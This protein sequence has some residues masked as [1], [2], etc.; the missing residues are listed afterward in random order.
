MNLTAILVDDEANSRTILRSYLGKYCPS[1]TVLGEAA[2]VQ[3]TLELLKTND[4]DM[5][6]LDVE[7][8]YGNAFDLIE[9]VPDRTFEI[10][11][12]T[13][14]DH[15][16]VDALNAQATYYLLKPIAIDNLIKAVDHVT[17]I[18]QREAA[19]QDQVLVPKVTTVEGKITIPQQDGFEVLK[20]EDILY[21]EADD[22]YTKIYLDKGQ[23]LVSKTL[24]YFEES[25]TVQGFAR[26]HKSYLVNVSKITRYRK[27]KG[28]SVVLSS[29]KELAVS[30][31]KKGMLLDYFK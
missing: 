22:N 8:P 5:L 31:S 4:P 23:K 7:M 17:H 15:Y 11:F 26:I 13:A 29:G 3:E 24:K 16:A 30:S 10:V 9:Q 28:G 19:L 25:L 14:Y 18:R 27:G 1:V 6:F 2:S 21:C 20:V 12:V